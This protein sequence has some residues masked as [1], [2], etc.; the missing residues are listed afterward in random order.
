MKFT[1]YTDVNEVV[2]E[3]IQ[4]LI[5]KYQDKLET[6]IRASDFVFNSVKLMH[7]KCH[8]VNYKRGGSYNDSLDLMKNKKATVNPNSKDN[9]CLKCA[10]NVPLDYKETESHT[11]KVSY[12]KPFI[13]KYN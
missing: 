5:S 8:K 10:A 3:L 7:Y 6:S 12:I 2:S 1:S 4:S 11:E 9:K 13:N